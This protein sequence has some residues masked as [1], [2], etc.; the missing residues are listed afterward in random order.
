[1]EIT[2]A[3]DTLK[4]PTDVR[5]NILA[6]DNWKDSLDR[7]IK[8][9]KTLEWLNLQLKIYNNNMQIELNRLKVSKLATEAAIKHIDTVNTNLPFDQKGRL[10]REDIIDLCTHSYAVGYFSAIAKAEEPETSKL[11]D[12]SIAIEVVQQKA[13]KM[14]AYIEANKIIDTNGNI[15]DY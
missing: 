12:A 3:L 9:L 8:L 1:M 14:Q 11:R 5:F 6:F 2:K 4:A 13:Q 10:Q 15:L 7:K